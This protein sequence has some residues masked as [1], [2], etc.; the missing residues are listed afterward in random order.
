L[1]K[2]KALLLA[3]GSHAR[4][5][6]GGLAPLLDVLRD[7]AG[8]E[9]NVADDYAELS[10]A[11]L[12]GYDMVINYSGYRAEVEASEPQLRDLLTAV[13]TGM[14]L[15]ALHAAA[16]MFRN[17]LYYRQPLGHAPARPVP[18]D[19]LDRIRLA[20]R[21]AGGDSPL[22]G[23][24]IES[25]RVEI[26]D[27]DH[28]ITKGVPDFEITDQLYELGG[29]LE[30]MHVLAQSRGKVVLHTQP[31]GEG[32]VHYNGLGHDKAA[33]GNPNYQ[34]LVVQAVGWALDRTAR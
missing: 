24:P 12:A 28:P 20:D 6:S 18:T 23:D 14:P 13:L 32:K 3:H 22:S 27:L 19:M 31:W 7:Q 10:L 34:R 21:D 9:L 30:R 25:H 17:Q 2:S 26:V 1:S 29:D 15:I 8:L 33:V 11:A 16:L 4:G 5:S